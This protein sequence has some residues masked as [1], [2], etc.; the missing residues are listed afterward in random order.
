MKTT[1]NL[2]CL[3][4]I[5]G[6]A[7][8][9]LTQGKVILSNDS[10]HPIVLKTAAPADQSGLNLPITTLPSGPIHASLW[11]GLDREHLL[12]QQEVSLTGKLPVQLEARPVVVSVPE[13]TR[14]FFQIQAQDERGSY[15]GQSSIFSA[16]PG[17]ELDFTKL[18]NY[19]PAEEL[20]V[21]YVPEPAVLAIILLGTALLFLWVL[22]TSSKARRIMA[23]PGLELNEADVH[24]VVNDLGE[25]GVRIHGKHFFLYKGESIVYRSKHDNGSPIL[26]RLVGKREFGEVQHPKDWETFVKPDGRYDRKVG[27][28]SQLSDQPR[29]PDFDWHPLPLS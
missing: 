26:V 7:N 23:R 29:N 22:L 19:W 16:V 5:G 14:A 28:H 24:W 4:L 13:N 3:A 27:F 10:Q 11:A 20:A 12:I 6:V 21:N 9:A 2:L 15:F 17:A 25:L 8:S 1:T 18:V